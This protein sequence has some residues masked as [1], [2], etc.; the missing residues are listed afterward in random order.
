LDRVH[1]RGGFVILDVVTLGEAPVAH[2]EF[3]DSERGLGRDRRRRWVVLAGHPLGDEAVVLLPA[4]RGVVL[5]EVAVL[6][7]DGD[8]GAVAGLVIAVAGLADGH[9]ATCAGA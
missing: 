9:G 7:V 5:A 2:A 3:D 8:D 4:L 6:A 1:F